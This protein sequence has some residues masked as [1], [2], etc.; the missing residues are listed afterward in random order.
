M[1][2][3]LTL[4]LTLTLTPPATGATVEPFTSGGGEHIEAFARVV[5]RLRD[6]MEGWV[7]Q[8]YIEKPLLIQGLTLTR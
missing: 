4:T 1:S 7:V 3:T 2:S 6:S 8:R 5:G